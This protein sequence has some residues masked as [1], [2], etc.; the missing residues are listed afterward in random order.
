MLNLKSPFLSPKAGNKARPNRAQRR[1]GGVVI[2]MVALSLTVLLGCGAIAVDY[3]VMVSDANQLQRASDAAALAGANKLYKS[4]VTQTSIT[5]DQFQARELAVAVAKRNGVA[6]TTADV[7]F[8]S[9]KQ[10]R[11]EATR[12]RSLFFAQAIGVSQGRITRNAL[13]GRVALKGLSGAVPMAMTTDDYYANRDGRLMDYE[14]IRNHDEDFESGSVVAIDLRPG[15]NGKSGAKF[16]EDFA[17]GYDGEVV[18]NQQ[19]LNALNAS[20]VSQTG[21]LFGAFNQRIVESA[22]APY[23]NTGSNYTYP[24]YKAGDPRIVMLIVSPPERQDNNNPTIEASFFVPVYLESIEERASRGNGKGNSNNIGG[25][26][27]SFRILPTVGYGSQDP[28]TTLDPSASPANRPST[29]TLQ[30]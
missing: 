24:N 14:L 21:K 15:N 2:V 19:S 7:S 30:R 10:I 22:R 6:I 17:N 3:G 28:D 29:V 25:T 4:G 16:Q 1:R 26:F 11:V 12:R 20:I 27:I 8:P 23:N 13:A 18:L 5:Y 9:D